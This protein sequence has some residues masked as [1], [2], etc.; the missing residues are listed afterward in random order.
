MAISSPTAKG[1]YVFIEFFYI[2]FSFVCMCVYFFGY[3]LFACFKFINT[4]FETVIV[5]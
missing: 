5:L 1:A 2:S 4:D 3:N